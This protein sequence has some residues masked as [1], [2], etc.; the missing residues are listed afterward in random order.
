MKISISTLVTHS[1]SNFK[2]APE[3]GLPTWIVKKV[4]LTFFK[5]VHA[6]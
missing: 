2:C 6:L 5:D 1:I 3:I 4:F